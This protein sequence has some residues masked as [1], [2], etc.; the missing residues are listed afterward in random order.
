MK[1]K[2][3]EEL[4]ESVRQGGTFFKAQLAQAELFAV[5]AKLGA[6]RQRQV[7]QFALR[8]TIHPYLFLTKYTGSGS[9]KKLSVW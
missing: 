3:F 4:L 5:Q 7:G 6:T 2:F 9:W 1:K 8:Q